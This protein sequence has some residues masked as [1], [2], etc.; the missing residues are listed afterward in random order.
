MKRQRSGSA[1]YRAANAASCAGPSCSGST[2]IERNLIAMPRL[3]RDLSSSRCIFIVVIGQT[4]SQRVK[5]KLTMVTWPSSS[6]R[7][8]GAPV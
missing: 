1:L 5:M 7:V 3:S 2:L 6:A 8:S 4:V